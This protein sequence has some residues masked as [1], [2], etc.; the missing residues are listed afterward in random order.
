M[1]GKPA[2]DGR[3]KQAR[4]AIDRPDQAAPLGAL[5]RRKE[6]SHD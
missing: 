6:I 2:A 3:A 4:D 5:V 1:L